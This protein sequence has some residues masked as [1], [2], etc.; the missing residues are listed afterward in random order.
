MN[1]NGVRGLI[2]QVEKLLVQSY[3]HGEHTM[4]G[5]CGMGHN[6]MEFSKCLSMHVSP[7]FHANRQEWP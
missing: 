7:Y 6:A 1:Y 2:C 5:K 3:Q 4:E